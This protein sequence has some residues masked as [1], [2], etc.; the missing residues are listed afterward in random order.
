MDKED[1]DKENK[2]LSVEDFKEALRKSA[3]R[4]KE[5]QKELEKYYRPKVMPNTIFY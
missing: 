5:T 2:K 4:A 1:I 3:I